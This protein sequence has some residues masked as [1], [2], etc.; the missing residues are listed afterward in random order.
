MKSGALRVVYFG[1]FRE[2]YARNQLLIEGLRRAGLD[3]TL[4]HRRLWQGTNDRLRLAGGGWRSPAFLLRLLRAYTG[5]IAD[6]ARLP[7]FDVMVAGFPGHYDVF[8]AWFLTRLRRKPLV[9]DVLNSVYLMSAE[10]GLQKRSPF[11]ISLLRWLEGLALH[12]PDLLILDTPQFIAWFEKEYQVDASRFRTVVIGAD[13]RYFRPLPEIEEAQPLTAIYYGGYIPNHGVE[14]IIE[15]ANLLRAEN[16]L[17]FEMIGEGP[18]RPAA[19]AL[20]QQYGLTNVTFIDWLERDELAKH[21][22]ASAIVLGA[23]S[24]SVQLSLTNNNKIY[25]GFAMQKAVISARTPALPP[26][27][28]SGENLLLVER[29]DPQGL[30]QAIL[31][32]Q[33]DPALRARLGAAGRKLFEAHFNPTVIGQSFAQIL[34]ELLR[35]P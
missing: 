3:V 11:T 17:R 21:I 9:W 19:Q 12:L 1:T 2:E 7:D 4:C 16:G 8:L 14:T 18:T 33:N 23:F 24:Q 20:A 28:K 26:L 31:N 15:A 30:A 10:R 27:L 35:K 6:F 29:A 32:L 34:R 22:A 5:L 13:D 25:E